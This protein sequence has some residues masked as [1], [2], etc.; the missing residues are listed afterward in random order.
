MRRRVGALLVAALLT[1]ACAGGSDD[2]PVASGGTT[3]PSTTAA[4]QETP[5]TDGGSSITSGSGATGGASTTA[6]LPG[7]GGPATTAA[8]GPAVG[9]LPVGQLAPALLQP[10]N[11]DRIVV[12]LRAQD[13]AAPTAATIDHLV[14]VLRDASG[15]QVA[16]DGPDPLAGDGR[17]WTADALT[18]AADGAAQLPQGGV[19]IVLRLLF[20]RGSFEGDDSVLGIAVSGDVAAVFSDQV[21]AAAGLLVAPDVVEDAVSVHEVGHLM[22]LVDLVVG[23]GRS[24]PAHPGHSRNQDSVMYW[25]VESDL[26]GQLIDGGIPNELDADDRAELATIRRD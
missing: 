19:Q 23:S 15:K 9:R 7:G 24:D 17:D 10:G 12:E 13:G 20:L 5:T 21:D 3:T 22:G 11:G 6:A 16:V 25:A 18:S 8:G 14:R 26:I 2:D 4:G 1:T